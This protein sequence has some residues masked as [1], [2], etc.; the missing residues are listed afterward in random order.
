MLP[1]LS[2]ESP[3]WHPGRGRRIR[4]GLTRRRGYHSQL[5]LLETRITPSTWTGAGTNGNWSN[6]ANWSGGAP[7]N[8]ASLAFPAGVSNLNAVNDLSAG[9]TFTSIEIDASGY[10][11]SGN[12][13]ALSQGITTT[14]S[15]GVTSDAIDT[16]LGGTVS[17]AAG[18]ELD[19]NG[20]LTSSVGLTVAGGGKVVLGGSS[21]NTYTGPTTVDGSTLV[22]GK[23][24]HAIAVPG[25]L[26]IGD[27]TSPATVQE[28]A[29]GQTASTTSVTVNDH[30]TFDL[31]GNNDAIGT[32]TLTGATVTT[33]T[34]TLTLGGDVTADDAATEDVSSISGNLDL[35]G[36]ART[37][38]VSETSA[39]TT[40]DVDLSIPAVIS[41]STAGITFTGGGEVD[42]MGNN[43]YTGP[44]TV[45]GSGTTLLVD[46]TIG[47]VG[48]GAGAT[49]GG[50]GT[51]GAV[52]STGGTI[53]P[54]DGN[55]PLNTATLTLDGSST[56]VTQLNGPASNAYGQVVATGAVTL[57]G[58][59][60][61]TLG[62]G[63]VPVVGDQITIIH[64]Q[65][66]SSVTGTFSGLLEGRT[67]TVSGHPFQITYK[68]GTGDD[69][70]LT[71][72]GLPTTT[73]VSAQTQSSTYGA[74][75]SFT[76]TVSAVA[77]PSLSGPVAFYDGNPASGG[78]L[79][80]TIPLN[81]QDQ[82]I[83]TTTTL[84]VAG[85][86]HQ[87]YAVY[88]GSSYYA[89]SGASQ[90][91]S[92][93]ISPATITV[94]LTGTVSKVY[95]GTTAATL[96][97]GNYQL[98]GVLG[99]SVVTLN[100]PT[101]GTYDTK[102]VGS[103]KV[104]S[105]TGLSIS[106]RDAANYTLA[107]S[108]ISGPF[109][110][111]T[112]LPLTVTGITAAA[113]VYDGTTAATIDTGGAALSGV[114]PGDAVNLVT[115][116]ATG[117]FT[118]PNAGTNKPVDVT[119]LSLSGAEAGDY[120]IGQPTATANI[121]PAPLTVT[122]QAATM[123]YGGAVPA[124]T[125]TTSPFV[126]NQTAATALTG[127][128]ATTATS[129]SHVGT[130]PITQGTLSAVNGNYTVSFT[131]ANLT[132]TPAPLT[133]T[134]EDITK[135]FG[136]PVPALTASYSGFVN[137]D[138]PASLATPPS[139]TTSA[140]SGSPVGSY[141]IIVAGASSNDYTITDV[142]GTLTINQASTSAGLS[143]SASTSVVG[144]AVTFS[145]QVAPVSPGAGQPSGTVTLLV[146]GN[147]VATTAVNPATG[148]ASFSTA[149]LG[150]G[151]HT[152][153]ATYAG[154][155]EFVSS[156]TGSVQ[157]TVAAA[158]TKPGLTALAIRNRRGK[159]TGVE[160][161]TRVS[162]VPPGGGVPTGAV[163]YFRKARRI[164]SVALSG[165]RAELTLKVNQALKQ[166]LTVQYGG[167]GNFSASTSAPVVLT[168]KSLK[169][170]V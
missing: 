28:T 74:S 18:G 156:Q 37:F 130:Y 61:A 60:D 57:G 15:S 137:N 55:G 122:A 54:G 45:V 66:G 155:S 165:G 125:Y 43:T 106:G 105:V 144:Q 118:D 148:Q 19:L 44:T 22:L 109:G 129:Q 14:Y 97:A 95:D 96:S 39:D 107:S 5:E 141:E 35:G 49:L 59:L 77:G 31:N 7:A 9:T 114:L 123:T 52:N 26:V 117:S 121:T 16:R 67:V 63:Y 62:T 76:A 69:V 99:T 82:A 102:D 143:S 147:P 136:S 150:R 56:F 8:G 162:V 127:S 72:L 71:A 163:T 34:G 78:T 108:S 17:V 111:I 151:P 93:T 159:I 75:L 65:S 64:N 100:D 70:V 168:R 11:L 42:L 115:T 149:S 135:V 120:S 23:S 73:T 58:T 20:A 83:Y 27:G 167:D 81:G 98:S 32:L 89:G 139:L 134:A 146:D 112:A 92:V 53:T 87:I 85:S 21:A 124:L 36:A 133:I 157:E 25:N 24:G 90:P 152:I 94:S 1:F 12:A 48:L 153:T 41:D 161:V 132:V 10:A 116:G 126:D 68:G 142:P 169:T 164:Q 88:G 113:K 38:T 128:L 154:D 4:R 50:S 3:D 104:V 145:V 160:L 110:V 6:P 101:S 46:G 30:G 140:T 170:L 131:G 91:A 13:I 51:V 79:L 47:A 86:P 80:Q 2:P 166:P 138:G 84:N 33:G 29:A 103:G 40:P 158:G 119:G